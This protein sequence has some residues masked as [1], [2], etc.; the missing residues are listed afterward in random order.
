M[1]FAHVLL[2]PSMTERVPSPLLV[3]KTAL[4]EGATPTPDGVFPTVTEET[5]LALTVS[6]TLS[7]LPEAKPT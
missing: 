1:V 2:E 6:I 4:V 5:A 7:V 3:V